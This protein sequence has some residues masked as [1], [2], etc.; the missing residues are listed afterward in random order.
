MAT[1]LVVD[2]DRAV[3]EMLRD[4]LT[5]DH[6]D[7]TTCRDGQQVLPELLKHSYDLLILDV[8]IPHMNG[9]VLMEK[10]RAEPSLKELP[11]V[12]LSGIY[13]SRNHRAEMTSRFGVIDY[14]DKP[15]N[16]ERLLDLVHRVMGDREPL[17]TPTA[18]AVSIEPKPTHPKPTPYLPRDP[19]MTTGEF[20]LAMLELLPPIK[21]LAAARLT[22]LPKPRSAPKPADT[23][24]DASLTELLDAVLPPAARTRPKAARREPDVRKVAA[25]E[26]E[27]VNPK[28]ID[29][30]TQKEQSEVENAVHKAF[31]PGAFLLQGSLAKMPVPALMG[32]LW[33]ERASGG[34]LLRRE[35]VKKIVYLREGDPYL[36]KSNLV[37]ECLGQVL[38]RERLINEAQCEASVAQ[39]KQ[40]GQHQGEILV[41]MGALTE[42]NLSFA[43]DLQ[44]E[45][46]LYDTFQWDVGE[47]RFNAT[48][49]IPKAHGTSWTGPMIVAE[50]LRRTFGE[51]RLEELLENLMDT[52]LVQSNET[53]EDV[54]TAVNEREAKAIRDLPLP[55]SPANIIGQLPFSRLENLRL[56]Y[57]LIALQVL[58]PAG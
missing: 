48:L 49:D 23:E 56:V 31:K 14:L 2:D 51:A 37:S 8:L 3:Q 34:L 22:P 38:L 54:R 42:R 46:K 4:L 1:I 57:A 12:M 13:R 45:T 21:P 29:T 35:G 32:H 44:L 30:S 10:L 41:A 43:L 24:L 28:I 26:P 33:H 47:Y 50:G 58:T 6:H 53:L 5:G 18:S 17:S 7:V 11:V 27:V 20:D 52:P 25:P 39:M 36:V 9:F 15:I 40:S 16:T 55:L 19:V